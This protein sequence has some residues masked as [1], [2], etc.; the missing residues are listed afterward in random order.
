MSYALLQTFAWRCVADG[1]LTINVVETG[2]NTNLCPEGYTY[3]TEQ[4]CIDAAHLG[5]IDGVDTFG[6]AG[7]WATTYPRGCWRQWGQ[8]SSLNFNTADTGGPDEYRDLVC[9][10]IGESLGA[11]AIREFVEIEAL[12]NACSPNFRHMTEAECRNFAAASGISGVTRFGQIDCCPQA[13]PIGCFRQDGTAHFNMATAGVPNSNRDLVCIKS[14]G[15]PDMVVPNAI[16]SDSLSTPQ[17]YHHGNVIETRSFTSNCGAGFTYMTEREC[18]DAAHLGLIDGVD[19][20]GDA[21]NWASRYPRGCWRQG[22]SLNFNTADTGG[23]DEYR[24]LVCIKI[25]E[26]F[27]VEPTVSLSPVASGVAMGFALLT[28]L[29]YVQH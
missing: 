19:T 13:C 20:F 6:D 15:V 18:I 8:G 5:L 4:E 26:A 9:I 27:E 21:G 25:G 14:A 24:D 29:L 28:A 16:A 2:S 11:P 1:G 10:K 3:M 23:P 17:Q 22:P 7:N 12:S